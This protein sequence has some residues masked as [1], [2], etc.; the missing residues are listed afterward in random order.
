MGPL[1]QLNH[2]NKFIR[3]RTTFQLT[4]DNRNGCV[5]YI[6]A[7]TDEGN[8]RLIHTLRPFINSLP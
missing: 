2:R 5:N 3:H 4:A 6:D 8:I 1:G 7:L